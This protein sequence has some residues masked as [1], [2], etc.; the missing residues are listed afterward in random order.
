MSDLTVSDFK[1]VLFELY[2]AQRENRELRAR[3]DVQEAFDGATLPEDP[4]PP[5]T[6][7]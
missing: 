5:D 1:D 4:A 6:G 3:Q 7:S 2:L